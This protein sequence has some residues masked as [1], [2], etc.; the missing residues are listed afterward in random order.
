MSG[1][2]KPRLAGPHEPLFGSVTLLGTA[3]TFA[4]AA[5]DALVDHPTWWGALLSLSTI[6]V[7][8]FACASIYRDRIKP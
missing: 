2:G 3:G 7:G 1:P 4:S 8:C 5:I 6:L